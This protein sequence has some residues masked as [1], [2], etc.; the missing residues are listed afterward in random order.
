MIARPFNDLNNVAWEANGADSLSDCINELM[1]RTSDYIST[2][3]SG[4]KCELQLSESNYPGRMIQILKFRAS[5]ST[6]NAVI[7]RLKEGDTVIRS[8]LQELTE[9]D[10]EYSIRLTKDEIALI[11][12]NNLSVELESV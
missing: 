8:H 7:V 11:T 5:S 9:I 1:P 4:S 3:V 12:S 10:T 2:I 6:G